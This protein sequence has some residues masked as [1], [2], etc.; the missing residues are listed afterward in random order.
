MGDFSAYPDEGG[1]VQTY[2]ESP[3]IV[4]S[5]WASMV[6][7]FERASDLTGHERELVLSS[8]PPAIA[9][10]VRRLLANAAPA[11]RFLGRLGED[12]GSAVADG[13]SLSAGELLT[14]RFRIRRLV[15]RGGMGEVY[16]AEDL[17]LD[18][19][20]ALKLLRPEFALSREGLDRFRHEIRLARS[21]QNPHI[22]RVHDIGRAAHGSGELVYFTMEL[23]PGET[24]RAR[25]SRL[26][27]L[28]IPEIRR[29]VADLAR[30][31]DA[32][33][34]LGI[35]HRDFKSNN[36]ILREEPDGSL[37]AVITDFGL[38][39]SRLLPTRTRFDRA[40]TPGY[41][42]PEQLRG[43][44]ESEATDIYSFGIVLFEMV[45]SRLPFKGE[46]ST[47]VAHARLTS[48]P[49][50]PGSL[51]KGLDRRW[52]AA[53]LRCL[54]LDPTRRP[55]SAIEVARELG[56]LDEPRLMTRR[57][58]AAA[59]A[60]VP[61]AALY[62][63]S[64]DAAD[65]RYHLTVGPFASDPKCPGDVAP[66]LAARIADLLTPLPGVTVIADTGP[67]AQ[68]AAAIAK[69]RV[70]HS[71]RGWLSTRDAASYQVRL[72]LV[73]NGSSEQ[74]WSG[75]YSV[76]ERE[77]DGVARQVSQAVIGALRL[78]VAPAVL[79]PEDRAYTRNPYAYQCYLLGRYKASLR[80][81][82][83]LLESE[84]QFEKAVKADPNFAMAYSALSATRSMLWPK[85]GIARGETVRKS[86]E[87]ASRALALDPRLS[88]AHAALGANLEYWDWDFSGAERH[89][90]RAIELG[91]KVAIAH[92]WFAKML[93]PLGRFDEA[94][95]EADAAVALDP[96][97]PTPK[98]AR[99]MVLLYAGR[100]EEAIGQ[101][102]MVVAGNPDHSNGYIPLCC[103]YQAAGR[104]PDAIAA[105][106]AGF[107]LSKEA[108][109]ALAHLTHL[110]AVGRDTYE[111]NERLSQLEQRFATGQATGCDLARAYAGWA[112]REETLSW[113]ER[114]VP[115]R[116][117]VLTTLLVDPVYAYL[118]SEPAFQ[119]L[120][121]R[122]GILL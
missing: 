83:Y 34:R 48:P 87:A 82:P 67:S 60:A 85:Q 6:E 71:L 30:G 15:A 75:T 36:V 18:E 53:I 23:L 94:L 74:V 98:I 16:E 21:I 73:R 70:T 50:L 29:I 55:Q 110:L 118:K 81:T 45:T 10:Q 100:V 78:D 41:V 35:L 102:R 99:G 91:P 101:C 115:A 114:G 33:H 104:I 42:A 103:A 56:C 14:G 116:D 92:H 2:R 59:I 22:C 49:S 9:D 64:H 54:A 17:D 88:E 69:R 113:L 32:A 79:S 68:Q 8:A 39:Q 117:Q 26:G 46:T 24:L 112:R 96:F 97:W 62:Y 11:Q 4:D 63:F 28:R 5:S 84:D 93:Y 107:L 7:L 77:M 66:G 105:A 80:D 106:R 25:I 120:C 95:R 43:E 12:I 31:L 119:A 72:A 58:A 61:A 121:K 40:W 51:R 1:K 37:Q 3:R 111:A 57:M 65:P 90:R 122:V 76:G 89:F 47:E 109:Y 38:A 86:N 108:S 20:V 13:Y 19:A 27:P 52:E 44:A